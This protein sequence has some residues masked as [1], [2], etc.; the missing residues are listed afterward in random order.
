[1]DHVITAPTTTV[2]LVARAKARLAA[3]GDALLVPER[4]VLLSACDWYPDGAGYPARHA[5]MLAEQDDDA[6]RS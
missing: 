6:P 2:S 5:D 1:M 4:W 3:L